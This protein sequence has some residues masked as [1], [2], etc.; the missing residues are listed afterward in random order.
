[1]SYWYQLKEIVDRRDITSQLDIGPGSIF[2]KKSLEVHRPD[3]A[4]QSMDIDPALQPDVVGSVTAIPFPDNSFDLLSAFQVLE[5]IEF[6]DF[7]SALQ[8]MKRVSKKYIF[9]SLPH[10]VPSF[11]MQFK[12]PGLKRVSFALKIPFGQKHVFNGQHYW[13]VGKQGYSAGKILGILK[14][15][16]SVIDEYVPH[17]NQYHHF[18]ILEKK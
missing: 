5:H 7:E 2:I 11:D 18:Y 17:E 15:H 1:M 10:N 4:Y 12:L 3:I 6:K 8:E 16:F 9:I 14:K 13:E